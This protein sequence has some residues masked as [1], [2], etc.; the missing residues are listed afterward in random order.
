MYNIGLHASKVSCCIA[1]KGSP[2]TLWSFTRRM[3]YSCSAG[4][5]NLACE[6]VGA[7]VKKICKQHPMLGHTLTM[8]LSC[9]PQADHKDH[10]GSSSDARCMEEHQML[11]QQYEP[12]PYTK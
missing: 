12:H 4:V 3:T 5:K 10:V 9:V 6:A 2:H 1:R 8:T 7:R 11:Q